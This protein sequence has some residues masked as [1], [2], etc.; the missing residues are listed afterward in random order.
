MQLIKY[1]L[2]KNLILL[3]LFCIFNYVALSQ[4]I[5]ITFNAKSDTVSIDSI[6]VLNLRT[7]QKVKLSGKQ[8]LILVN[9]STNLNVLTSVN[10]HLIVYPNPTREH[11]NLSFSLPSSQNVVINLYNISGQLLLRQTHS[12]H[13]GKHQFRVQLPVSG[14]YHISVST[15]KNLLNSK[16][17]YLGNQTGYTDVKY[18][19]SESDDITKNQLKSGSSGL[20]NNTLEFKPGD[21]IHYTVYSGEDITLIS[22]TPTESTSFDVEFFECIDPDGKNYKIVQIGDQV[23]MAENLAWLPSVSSPK[24][25]SNTAPY[26][27]VYGY[28]GNNVAAAKATDN[29]KI[30][31]VLYNW[32]AALQ[33]C[34]S[35]WHLPGDTEWT[36]LENYLADKGYNYDGTI[37]GGGNKIGKSLAAS[38]HW[39]SYYEDDILGNNVFENN[40]SGFSALPG[41]LRN[42]P[43]GGN[44]LGIRTD[45]YWW[46]A[47]GDGNFRL[48]RILNFQYAYIGMNSS[49]KENGFSI[50]CVRDTLTNL[51]DLTISAP[52]SGSIQ[53]GTLYQ[54][55]VTVTKTKDNMTT[56]SY[57]EAH[58]Y[59]SKTYTLGSDKIKLWESNNIIPNFP[60]SELNS[61]GSKTVTA[62]I[63]I[64]ENTAAG[65]YFI[66]AIV[67][68][69]NF[70]QE[71]NE[72]NNTQSNLIVV[73][74]QSSNQTGTFTDN[75]D[76]KT[77]RWVEIGDQTWMAENLA[78]L[79]SVNPSAQGSATATY[80]YVYNYQ[81]SDVEAAKQNANYKTYGVLYNWPAA[82]QSCPSGWHLPGDAEW[83]QLEMAL[84]MTQSQA[85]ATGWRGTDQGTK[86]KATSGWENNGN[87][88][89][90][91][92]FSALPGGSRLFHNGT[93]SDSGFRGSWWSGSE[94]V[95]TD[96]WYRLLTHNNTN[97]GR[98]YLNKASGLSV[99]CVRDT[100]TTIPDLTISAPISGSIQ[101]GGSKQILVTVT[102]TGAGL[103]NGNFVEAHIYLSQTSKL[104]SGKILLWESNSSTPDFPN[105]GLNLNGSITVTATITIPK[106]II[107]GDFYIIA[108]VDE[109]NFHQE[110]RETNNTQSNP[111]KVI[112]KTGTFTDERDNKAYKWVEIGDQ[113]WMAENLAYLPAVSPSSQGSETTPL[114]YVYD[115]HDT[116]IAAAKATDNYKTYGVLYNWSSAIQSCPSGWHLPN[117]AEWKQMEMILGMTQFQAD[118]LGFRGTNQGTQLKAANGWFLN[119]N[120]TNSSGFTALPGGVYWDGKFNNV[121]SS[122]YW[123]SSSVKSGADVWI[124]NL[125]YVNPTV[126]HVYFPKAVGLSVRCIKD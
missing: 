112:Y 59:L 70:H 87:G 85:E 111:L 29:Y 49:P 11:A 75:R 82:L 114:Y 18:T 22:D 78:Y 55:Q 121:G 38:E 48:N 19:G 58:L 102:K 46:T 101:V 63:A 1:H 9:T 96:V 110:T 86:L 26:Y 32:T 125:L 5:T 13:S 108:V 67:D 8:N 15:D 17:L 81:G 25:G 7:N 116:D 16:V 24:Q 94:R 14:L 42:S 54:V 109:V 84:E 98:T 39:Y 107:A 115:Y 51:P 66:V 47:T 6:H 60:N 89:Y 92:G 117:D 69:V 120:G 23:W 56:G 10:G 72:T 68:E 91:N 65:D 44:F 28:Q 64:P 124:R 76:N 71:T 30:Y 118:S 35:G 20:D 62:T 74:V 105:S 103:T 104:D 21:V 2:M 79:P 119:Y 37:G 80:Y 61:N 53:T 126:S 41:G 73:K 33:A 40:K 106:N 123:W 97:V 34:P 88:I 90:T 31:G 122:G 57:V 27:Y 93:F 3:C 4:D 83:K 113:T 45:G 12:L 99:R 100:L 95:I 36:Q 50:R 52:I 77:Y 43:P